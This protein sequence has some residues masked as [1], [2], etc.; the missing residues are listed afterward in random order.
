[1][2]LNAVLAAEEKRSKVHLR[3]PRAGNEGCVCNWEAV[4]SHFERREEG[5][6][7]TKAA[8]LFSG[9]PGC[10]GWGPVSSQPLSICPGKSYLAGVSPITP[11]CSVT[12][13]TFNNF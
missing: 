6:P 12:Y 2:K 3:D 9:F 11:I 4:P 10:G 7:R 13:Q 5:Q 8:P 1:M